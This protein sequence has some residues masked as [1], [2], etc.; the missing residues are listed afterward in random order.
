[1]FF[2]FYY[3]SATHSDV[4]LSLK[5]DVVPSSSCKRVYN[6]KRLNLIEGQICAGGIKGYYFV[7][8]KNNCFTVHSLGQDSCRGDSGGPLMA[9]D[10]ITIPTLAY[11]Y[12]VGIVSFGPT[13]CGRFSKI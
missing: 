5:L 12:A 8:L 13:P 7:H 6:R 1:M 10:D 3:C 2:K 9:I 4:K 11:Y